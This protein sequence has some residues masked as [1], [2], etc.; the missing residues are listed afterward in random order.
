MLWSRVTEKSSVTC[1]CFLLPPFHFHYPLLPS[2]LPPLLPS[3]PSS[4]LSPSAFPLGL[5]SSLT[6]LP[7]YPQGSRDTQHAKP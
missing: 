1:D 4:C 3:P 2:L 6:W 7:R 5:L